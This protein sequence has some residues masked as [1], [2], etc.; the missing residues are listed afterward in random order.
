MPRHWIPRFWASRLSAVG[1]AITTFAGCTLLIA[2]A[3]D[4]AGTHL[5]IYATAVLFL[6]VPGFFVLG[7]L[8]IPLGLILKRRAD[9]KRGH[10]VPP[11]GPV[12]KALREPTVRRT[13][14]VIGGL[15]VINLLLVGG[16]GAKA[17]SFMETPRFCGTMC[18][19]IMEPE[20]VAYQRS[21]HSRVACVDCH[22]GPG[23]SWAVKSKLD[24]LRQVWH[25][26]VG[27]YHRPIPT[28]VHTLRPAR[29]TCEKC[30]W[31]SKFIGNK[32]LTHVHYEADKDNTVEVTA[33]AL[34]VGG[35]N[36]QTGTHVGIHWHVSRDT[37]VRYEALDAKREKIGKVQVIKGGKVVAEYLPVDEKVRDAPVKEVRTMDCVDCHNR[38]THQYDGS[39]SNAIDIGFQN[40]LLDPK[41]PWL[42]KVAI[43]LLAQEDRVRSTAETTFEEDLREAYGKDHPEVKLTD[44]Q[45][46]AA[47]RGL[48][49]LYRRN[50]WPRMDLGWD[51]YHNHIGHQG[52]KADT[53][54]CYRCHDEKHKTKDGK[55]LSQDCEL[56][57]EL[58]AEDEAPDELDDE[59]KTMLYGTEK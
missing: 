19:K 28:P 51:T 36:A 35:M 2:I 39:P 43:P 8:L 59:L 40:G 22:I 20:Y 58:L 3:A 41:T 29:D 46:K 4:F 32:L 31:P 55:V 54:G 53:R 21:P 10:E 30:H 38:P 44:G 11:D 24:G 15:T 18:H 9:I 13:L 1:V 34:R 42:K 6:I 45:V 12:R 27:D 48:A 14:T 52:E 7:L 17:V 37:I 25:A 57:H 50:I 16:A 5:N 26:L 47:A 33:L 56:C 49:A 23:A